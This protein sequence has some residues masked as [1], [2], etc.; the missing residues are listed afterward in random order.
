[1]AKSELDEWFPR[2]APPPTQEEKQKEHKPTK[3]KKR[4]EDWTRKYLNDIFGIYT[5][6]RS[7]APFSIPGGGTVTPKKRLD[8][9]GSVRQSSGY[10]AHLELEVKAFTG[11]RFSLSNIKPHQALLLNEAADRGDLA[12]ISFV[13]VVDGMVETMWWIPWPKGY[14]GRPDLENSYGHTFAW[15]MTELRGRAS[16]NFQAKSIRE[17]DRDLLEEWAVRKEKGVWM[18]KSGHWLAK[19]TGRWERTSQAPLL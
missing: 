8:F 12:M 5:E 2:D 11:D 14:P 6:K 17:Q 3:I 9:F 7:D 4:G 15:M 18:A 16:G 13:H 1:M 19:V 10:S